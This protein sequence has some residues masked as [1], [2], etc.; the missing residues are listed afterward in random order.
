MATR[1]LE[2]EGDFR[3][4]SLAAIVPMTQLITEQSAMTATGTSAQ[5][6]ALGGATT[7]ICVQSDEA[8]YV[9]LGTNPTATGN[10]YRLQAGGEQFFAVAH[11]L[12]WKVAIKT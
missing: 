10:S 7:F 3:D 5:S 8:V 4:S 2:F 12:S 11:G 1:I 9:E 6:S